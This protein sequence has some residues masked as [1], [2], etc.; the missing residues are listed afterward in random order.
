MFIFFYTNLEF[1]CQR[2]G[3][4]GREGILGANPKFKIGIY[5]QDQ[6]T[7]KSNNPDQVGWK[8]QYKLQVCIF[9]R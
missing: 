5:S 2:C 1:K 9:L 6:G 8:T 4:P 3:V 7:S